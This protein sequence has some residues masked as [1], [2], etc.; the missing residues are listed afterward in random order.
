MGEFVTEFSGLRLADADRAGGKGASL[1]ELVAA[2]LPVPPGSPDL[3]VM[4]PFVRTR[5]ELEACL[6]LIE[7]SERAV[8]SAE[9]RIL[10]DYALTYPATPAQPA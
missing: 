6:E 8:A 7:A 5:W 3:H 4:T 1:G 2:G 10:L 9:R